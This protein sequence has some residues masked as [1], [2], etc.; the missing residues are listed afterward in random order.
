[1]PQVIPNALEVEV[2]TTL[3]TP[4]LTMKIYGNNVTPTGASTAASFTEISGGG[5]TSKPLTFANWG[6]VSGD[7]SIATYNAMQSFDFTGAIAGPGTIYGYFVT[8]NSDGKLMW[9][10]R[11]PP[12]NVPFVPVAGSKIQILP[13]LSAQSLF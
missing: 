12:A 2:L 8:R 11:F 13:K 4:A 7:P 5:Y 10:E 9:A 3:L 1:M 6:I